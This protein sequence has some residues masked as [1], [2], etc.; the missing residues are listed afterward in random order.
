MAAEE[1]GF[2]QLVQEG[3]FEIREYGVVI[4]AETVLNG[5]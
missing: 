4:V 5:C 3:N 2:E 1:P